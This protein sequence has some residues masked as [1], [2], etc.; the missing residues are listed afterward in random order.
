MST[1]ELALEASVPFWAAEYAIGK[2][3]FG[4]PAN[5][6][7]QRTEEQWLKPQIWK[8]W[9]GSGVYGAP[10]TTVCSMIG[11]AAEQLR[12]VDP[13]LDYQRLREVFD[14]LTFAQEELSHYV[15][16]LGLYR[17]RFGGKSEVPLEEWG[18]LSSG[19]ALT[20]LRELHRQGRF[21]EVIVRLSEGGGLGLFYGMRRAFSTRPLDDF[22]QGLS[23]SVER[24]LADEELHLSAN[25][26]FASA[27][28]ELDADW[29][30]VSLSLRE[31]SDCKLKEREE[32]FGVSRE[33][34]D[35]DYFAS[36]T[37][38]YRHDYLTPL[39]K[40]AKGRSND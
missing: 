10:G 20:S 34:I 27:T 32:Q 11:D 15:D 1:L 22:D 39:I 35:Q 23:R 3:Y 5:Q 30:H 25:M 29:Q 33:S 24:I 26:R 18:S 31:I 4:R 8:E 38:E 40:L 21:G 19:K 2:I 36:A 14:Y 16:L 17:S 9:Y 6:R 28:L 13:L 7:S 37:Q 12:S